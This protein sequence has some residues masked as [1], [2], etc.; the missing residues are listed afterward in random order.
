[1]RNKKTWIMVLLV[2]VLMLSVTSVYGQK[3]VIWLQE[4]GILPEPEYVLKVKGEVQ[5]NGIRLT[6]NQSGKEGFVGYKVVASKSNPHPAYPNDGYYCLLTDPKTTQ[7]LIDQTRGYFSGD[8]GDHFTPGETYFFSVTAVYDTG[9]LVGNAVKLKYPMV[10]TEKPATSAP[11]GTTVTKTTQTSKNTVKETTKIT[12]KTTVKATTKTTSPTSGMQVCQ[13][14]VDGDR[15]KMSWAKGEGD[16]FQG[17]KIVISQS[18]SQPKYP[19]D[20]YLYWITNKDTTNCVIDNSTPYNGGSFGEYLQPG[21]KYYFSVT[22]VYSDSKIPANAVQLKIPD[23]MRVPQPV[24][25]VKPVITEILDEGNVVDYDM[26]V[27]WTWSGDNPSDVNKFKAEIR[28]TETGVKEYVSFGTEISPLRIYCACKEKTPAAQPY[29]YY[30]VKIF[31]I[32][33]DGTVVE[34]EPSR[35]IRTYGN[36]E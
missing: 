7:V 19:N 34:S 1:M 3:G 33:Q 30:V 16:H 29:V 25:Y 14:W 35:P 9:S 27:R 8:F 31:A 23:G 10:S 36:T 18:N 21:T 22:Y 5:A 15:I 12:S 13:A 11:V 20:G 26:I 28:N 6:W 32:Y 24:T 17:Y 4:R 2:V